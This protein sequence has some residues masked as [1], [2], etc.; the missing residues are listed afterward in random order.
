MSN[1]SL[2][3]LEHSAAAFNAKMLAVVDC[4]LGKISNPSTLLLRQLLTAECMHCYHVS[5]CVTML[6]VCCRPCMVLP[7]LML[8]LGL[9]LLLLLPWC[10]SVHSISPLLAH[11]W[12]HYSWSI[13]AWNM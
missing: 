3:C 13:G 4:G 1:L 5:Q 2:T 10:R 6:L 8:V 12:G 7:F 9:L 11:D